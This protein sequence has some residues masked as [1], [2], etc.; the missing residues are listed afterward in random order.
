MRHLATV[1]LLAAYAGPL[2]AQ[3]GSAQ[4]L[5]H[6]LE[7]PLHAALMMNVQKLQTELSPFESDGCSGGLSQAWAGMAHLFPAFAQTYDETPPW[8]ACCTRHDRAYHRAGGANDPDESIT[9]R[10]AADNAL[11][12]CVRT[13]G[14]GD[15]DPTPYNV[16]AQTMFLAVRIGGGPCSG[17]SWRWGYGY[18]A[19]NDLS[20]RKD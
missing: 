15:E 6:R 5:R 1:M 3:D 7:R 11:K 13:A 17:L 2:D 16:I 18:P 10:L 20:G 4:S 9:A 19:C 12:A 8:E 14:D